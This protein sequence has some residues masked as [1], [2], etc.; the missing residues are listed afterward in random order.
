VKVNVKEGRG[1]WEMMNE[2]GQIHVQ[3]S[4]SVRNFLNI[5]DSA[6]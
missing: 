5:F 2:G 4:V 6:W 3:Y 1:L